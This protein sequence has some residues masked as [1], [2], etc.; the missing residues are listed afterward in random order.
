MVNSEQEKQWDINNV[1]KKQTRLS[2]CFQLPM[3]NKFTFWTRRGKLLG[4]ALENKQT[5]NGGQVS[6]EGGNNRMPPTI[7][8]C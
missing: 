3:H 1:K 6:M 2:D 5:D 7:T 4:Q 8:P